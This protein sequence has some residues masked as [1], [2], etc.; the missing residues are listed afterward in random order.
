VRSDF[1]QFDAILSEVVGDDFRFP[2]F[3]AAR[4]E[5]AGDTDVALKLAP[6]PDAAGGVAPTVLGQLLGSLARTSYNAGD[7]K[8]ARKGLHEWNRE[9]AR[10]SRLSGGEAAS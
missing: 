10:F 9:F 4:A 6:R 7:E 3:R 1:R 8:G 5:M 2:M